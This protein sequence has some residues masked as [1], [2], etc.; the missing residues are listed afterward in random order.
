[1]KVAGTLR[2]P[3]RTA[4]GVCLLLFG[5]K[6]FTAPWSQTEFEK[7]QMRADFTL[8][9]PLADNNSLEAIAKP[10]PARNRQYAEVGDFLVRHSHILIALWDGVESNKVGGTSHVLQ[11]MRGEVIS[12]SAPNV[13]S[14]VTPRRNNPK[15]QGEVLTVRKLQPP[16]YGTRPANHV[17]GDRCVKGS[18]H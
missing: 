16:E 5:S 12:S 8:E 11:F 9:L 15:P 3:L 7:L 4:H 13:Y 6:D 14:I 2:V 18:G 1:M 10:G 17:G